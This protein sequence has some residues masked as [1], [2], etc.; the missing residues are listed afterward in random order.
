MA[1]M[2]EYAYTKQNRLLT[3]KSY[4]RLQK[5]HIDVLYILSIQY[6]FT[7]DRIVESFQKL[8]DRRFSRSRKTNDRRESPCWN[9]DIYIFQN[10]NYT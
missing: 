4:T 6:Y 3:D 7:F 10:S 9:V 8:G 5:L 2:F 1:D